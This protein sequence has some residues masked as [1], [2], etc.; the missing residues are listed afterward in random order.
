MTGIAEVD[1][2][3][4]KSVQLLIKKTGI[5]IDDKLPFVLIICLTAGA[6]IHFDRGWFS[7]HIIDCGC[8]DHRKQHQNHKTEK[9][10][11]E[12]QCH[13]GKRVCRR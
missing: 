5:C 2:A 9:G 8:I 6:C 7:L 10:H 11:G 4:I 12:G 13:F 1:L 3:R